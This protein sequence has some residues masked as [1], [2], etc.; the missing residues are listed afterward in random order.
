M[1]R[2]FIAK[3]TSENGAPSD[4]QAAAKRRGRV[5]WEKVEL[6]FIEFL[7]RKKLSRRRFGPRKSEFTN[8][9]SASRVGTANSAVRIGNK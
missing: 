7:N 5:G 6:R 2:K 9:T 3:L 8:E 4:E 1:F